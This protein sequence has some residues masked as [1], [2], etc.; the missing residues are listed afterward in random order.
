MGVNRL[1][2]DFETFSVVEIKEGLDRYM[3]PGS[4]FEVTLTALAFGDEAVM[5]WEGIPL[6][7]LSALACSRGVYWHAFNAPF[8]QRCLRHYAI[9]VPPD[10]WRCTQ[11]HAYARGFAGSLAAVGDQIGIAHGKL[12]TGTR[13]IHK[14]AKP[15]PKNHKTRRY[16]CENSPADWREFMAYNIRDVVAEREVWR[17][18]D[19]YPW[20][21]A[22]QGLWELDRVINETG[23]PVDVGMAEGAVT[24]AEGFVETYSA[25]VR[26]L[27]GGIG[28]RQTAALLAW[29]K[30]LGYTADNL[31]SATIEEFLNAN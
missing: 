5:Q 3:A 25:R 28:P 27:T 31:Q 18:L 14:F 12:D 16:T 17:Y 29:C 2:L 6:R 7:F 9:H 21:P 11:A 30:N 24:L 15:A 10:R 8:E 20:T 4:G 19:Q 13:L 26:E 22:E 23:I 1:H